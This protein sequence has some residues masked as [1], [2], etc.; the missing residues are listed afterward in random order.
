MTLMMVVGGEQG[1][2]WLLYRIG[3]ARRFNMWLAGFEMGFNSIDTYGTRVV[4]AIVV[5]TVQ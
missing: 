5:Q 3:V 1:Y 2:R 4:H